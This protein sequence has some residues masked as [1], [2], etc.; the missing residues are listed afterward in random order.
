[1]GSITRYDAMRT[2]LVES[3]RIDD[4]KEIRDKAEAL[5]LY[6]KQAGEGLENQNMMAEIKLRAERRCGELLGEMENAPTGPK[7][8]LG[9]ALLRNSPP[10]TLADMGISRMQ[11]SRWQAIAAVPEP[12]F[13]EHL[14]TVRAEAAELT[15]AGVLRVAQQ[16]KREQHSEDMRK[17]PPL[18]DAKYRVWYADPPWSYG[19]SGVINESDSYGRAARHYPSMSIEALCDMG[20]EIRSKCEPDA[21]LFMWVT[22]PLLAECFPVIDAWGFQYKSSFVWDK[23]GHNFGHYNS[24]RHEFLLVATRGSCL[25]DDRTLHD[26]VLSIPKSDVHSQKPEEFRRMIDSLYTW[27]KRIELFARAQVEGWDAWGNQA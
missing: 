22:S 3:H 14:A 10:P 19:N 16:I 6:A 11:S 26:S 17:A 7:P 15:S 27:G 8:Q 25:P 18:P 20:A 2:A 4:V 13:E 24:V 9:N 23:V 12:I 1:M 5:R 21:V